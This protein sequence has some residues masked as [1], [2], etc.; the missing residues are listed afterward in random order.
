MVEQLTLTQRD[1]RQLLDVVDAGRCYVPGEQFPHEA[2]RR[3]QALIPSVDVSFGIFR[4]YDAAT[5]HMDEADDEPWN[6]EYCDDE[7]RAFYWNNWWHSARS[8]ALHTGDFTSVWR[9]SDVGSRYPPDIHRRW[10]PPDFPGEIIV[11]FPLR[12]AEYESLA[13]FRERRDFSDREL[14][15]LALLR[16]HLWEMRRRIQRHQAGIP[17]LSA[18]QREILRLVAHGYTNAEIARRL[19][20]AESTVRKHLENIY[21]RLGVGTRTAAVA[22]AFPPTVLP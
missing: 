12:G 2:L 22:A 8:H 17:E 13:L 21:E 20:V 19:F 9:V 18:R 10:W 15:L 3:L 6:G 7:L 11:P 1:L 16:P 14:M 4:P 5:I